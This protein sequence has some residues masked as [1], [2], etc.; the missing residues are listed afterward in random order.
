MTRVPRGGGGDHL[1][2]CR[3]VE[4]HPALLSILPTPNI[5]PVIMVTTP[6]KLTKLQTKMRKQEEGITRPL[7][8]SC[9]KISPDLGISGPFC[10]GS[11]I[12]DHFSS[13]QHQLQILS[14]KYFQPN[15]SSKTTTT[16]QA[17]KNKTIKRAKN[18]GTIRTLRMLTV[19]VPFL[20]SLQHK[21][22]D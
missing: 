18:P 9:P 19:N 4:K 13:A 6:V 16:K 2:S 21:T 11:T 20:A 8:L 7:N 1:Y 10:P 22:E 12:C 3:G 14:L 15:A 17:S 5:L